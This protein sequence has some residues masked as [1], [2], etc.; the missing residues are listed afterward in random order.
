[1]SHRSQ[2]LPA[3][4]NPAGESLD[5]DIEDVWR[6]LDAE[7]EACEEMQPGDITIDMI[8]ERYQISHETARKKINT[9]VSTGKFRRVKIRGSVLGVYRKIR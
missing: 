9:L 2:D 5:I 7:I 1:M 6:E 3:Q 4:E 8:A